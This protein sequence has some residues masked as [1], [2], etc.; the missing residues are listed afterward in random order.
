MKFQLFQKEVA[1]KGMGLITAGDTI[2]ITH[3]HKAYAYTYLNRLA[4]RGELVRVEKGKY[5]LP[6]TPPSVIASNL[7][8]PSYISLLFGLYLHHRTT[9]IPTVIDII[10]PV[11]KKQ[12]DYNG[13]SISFVKIPPGRMFG[14][15]SERAGENWMMSL[16]D[17][18]KVI[19]D[20]LYLPGHCPLQETYSAIEE[21]VNVAKLI[22]FGGRMS[23]CVTLKRL[24]Y[25]LDS[26]GIDIY[27]DISDLINYK[28][29][30]LDPTAPS[31]G[32]EVLRNRKWHLLI[33]TNLNTR[34]D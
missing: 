5:A 20:C 23:S 25:L 10:S 30:P 2:K 8:H 22:D 31:D 24:G 6:G 19:I 11:S 9:Q 4:T 16:G 21:G 14:Y 17:L 27:R 7:I 1:S 28:L 32:R 26:L 33:N 13:Y 34:E 12:I 3:Y 18:E 15:S 29:D